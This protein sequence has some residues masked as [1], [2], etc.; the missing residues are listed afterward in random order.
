[1]LE[2]MKK[3][4]FQQRQPKRQS[5]LYHP[6]MAL[7]V[8]QEHPKR[9]SVCFGYESREVQVLPWLVSYISLSKRTLFICMEIGQGNRSI[10]YQDLA[11][12]D[13]VDKVSHNQCLSDTVNT[14]ASLKFTASDYFCYQIFAP[15]RL[16]GCKVYGENSHKRN[17]AVWS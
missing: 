4:R 2:P 3:F 7:L 17:L 8:L 13:C 14:S 12:R 16:F 11:D 10:G 6:A 1:M 5:A 15:K 9:D